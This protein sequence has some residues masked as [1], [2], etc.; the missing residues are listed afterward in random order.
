VERGA[1]LDL[2]PRKL[3]ALLDRADRADF[4]DD[5]RE[6]QA[7]RG[8]RTTSAST[9]RSSPR[10]VTVKL[11]RRTALLS[12]R[13]EPPTT[14]VAPRPPISSGAANMATRST[15]PASRKAP[16]TSP[17]PSTSTAR[18]SRAN[19]SVRSAPRST[20]PSRIRQGT[21]VAPVAAIASR[22]AGGAAAPTATTAELGPAARVRAS[23]GGNA[24]G[25]VEH[26]PQRL[27]GP[28]LEKT[29]RELRIVAQHRSDPHHDRVR[30]AAKP[31]RALAGE[32]AGDPARAPMQIGNLAVE[33]HPGLQG[34]VGSPL[35]HRCEEHPVL[36]LGFHCSPP[37][38][39]R[40]AR[41]A[42]PGEAPAP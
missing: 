17:P 26:D 13:P 34:D 39:D 6:H 2:E 12:S 33:G 9:R 40:D 21:I 16:W 11:P 38:H 31:V 14:G 20:R 25:S 28:G 29:H 3:R 30:F 19:S 8:S 37:G 10:G 36:A 22:R 5:A 41:C 18:T 1:R 35:A 7:L 15:R 4:L 42:Q 23:P 32:L 24:R 27:P